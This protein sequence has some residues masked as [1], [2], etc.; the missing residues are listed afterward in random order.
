M[1]RTVR[2]DNAR[3]L[4]GLLAIAAMTG[5]VQAQPAKKVDF[6][7]DVEP[8]LKAR[9]AR[10]H[11]NGKYKGSF[12]LDTRADVLKKK[13]VVPGKSADSEIIKRITSADKDVRMPPEGE[14][15]S[16]REIALLRTWI[17]EGFAWED[18]F[19]FKVATY[20][21][22]LK[23]R[24]PPLPPAREGHD[25]PIDRIIEA[26]VAQHK[27]SPPAPLDDPAFV[28]RIYLDLIGVLPAP[29]EVDA[30]LK[31]T[32]ADK[33]LN[34]IHKLLDDKRSF[35][36][37]WLTFWNDMLRNDYAGTGY[38]DGGRKQI[39]GWLY[40]SLLENKPYDQF[41]RELIAPKPES[42]GFIKGIK[43]RGT[44]NA[45]QVTEL[46]FSQNVSQ[47]FFGIN[48]KCA[49]CHDS[50]ID[51]WKLDDAY[52]MAAIIADAPLEIYRCDKATG[53][54]ASARF[55]FPELG[56]IDAA[57]PKARRLEQL[58]RL[59]THPDNGRFTR[60]MANR[61]WQRFLGRGI[62]HPVDV[63][64]N[65]PWSE[66]LLDYLGVYLVDQ[67]YDLKKLIEHI[68]T[69]RAYQ[70]RPVPIPSELSGE[71]YVFRGPEVRRMTAEQFTDAIWML[72]KTAPVKA[73]APM[74]LPPFADSVP[75]ER[76]FVRAALV[77]ADPLMR[78]LGRPNREQ[79][80]TTRPDQLTTLE[81]LDLTNGKGLADLLARGAA[82]LLKDRPRATADERVEDIYRRALC[83]KPTA[84]EL[85]AA[86][87]ILGSPGT[88]EGLADLLWAV[89]MLPEFQLIR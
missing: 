18:G 44:V 28:R 12:S 29:D 22:P 70:S 15:L 68:V 26:Y 77:N 14:P 61:F 45:S 80:V 53:R 42:E 76:R 69:S 52:G 36:E 88:A 27:V 4:L 47:V 83:R 54:K 82:N 40:A 64:A 5:S 11:T 89:V 49:S 37:H 87:D 24:R 50:F 1:H 39:S 32:A 86:R 16:A 38:I 65:Q 35:A 66:D 78:S 46:Q 79:V 10:C 56:T 30:F 58:A 8:I 41:V 74:P 7:H 60:T 75:V 25:H 63:M 33:R 81:A 9:C 34:L 20:V 6:A 84:D 71:D 21:P 17:D 51:K 55:V 2:T 67:K 57:Q 72:T 19:S 62:V 13:A 23:P 73:A 85:A 31:D 48:M 3:L 43:W 59:V